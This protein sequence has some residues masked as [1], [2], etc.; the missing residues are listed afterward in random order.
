MRAGDHSH[1]AKE[2]RSQGYLNDCPETLKQ[3]QGSVCSRLRDSG[4]VAGEQLL[5]RRFVAHRGKVGM[6]HRFFCGKAFL[7]GELA[8]RSLR[9]DETWEHTMWSYR[10][11]LSRKSMASLLTNF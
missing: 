5:Q 10:S 6:R 2:S 8:R 1:C 11:S 4:V 3:D 9:R 7:E